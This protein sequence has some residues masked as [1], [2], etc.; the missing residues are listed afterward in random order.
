[1]WLKNLIAQLSN[2][3]S[4]YQF[5]CHI[6]PTQIYVFTFLVS[7]TEEDETGPPQHHLSLPSAE[8]ATGGSL[9]SPHRN[10]GSLAMSCDATLTPVPQHERQKKKE[11]HSSL[12]SDKTLTQNIPETHIV[13]EALPATIEVNGVDAGAEHNQNGN[14]SQVIPEQ[15]VKAC[16]PMQELVQKC[17]SANTGEEKDHHP[18]LVRQ[19]AFHK[20]DSSQ[21]ESIALCCPAQQEGASLSSAV[22]VLQDKNSSQAP[23]KEKEPNMTAPQQDTFLQNGSP[24]SQGTDEEQGEADSAAPPKNHVGDGAAC[25][26]PEPSNTK[27]HMGTSAE[28]DLVDELNVASKAL[29]CLEEHAYPSNGQGKVNGEDVAGSA[30]KSDGGFDVPDGLAAVEEVAPLLP[31]GPLVPEPVPLDRAPTSA[32]APPNPQPKKHKL[33]RRNKKSSQEGNVLLFSV[34]GFSI[35]ALLINGCL[36]LCTVPDIASKLQLNSHLQIL[37]TK[38]YCVVILSLKP[39]IKMK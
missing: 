33:F 1:M 36:F 7:N 31:S 29:S 21:E 22:D 26:A 20:S 14:N 13:P 17:N 15:D 32:T 18:C 2:Y 25:S 24:S 5:N 19:G 38:P 3:R 10:A 12:S 16:S 27:C 30:G 9:G 4:F 28:G 6:I 8:E 39:K 23:E 34:Q 35:T 37:P 11:S